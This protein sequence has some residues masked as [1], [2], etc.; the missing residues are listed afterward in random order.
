MCEFQHLGLIFR[1]K[2][3]EYLS[4]SIANVLLL[5]GGGTSYSGLAHSC[6]RSRGKN[7]LHGKAW[8]QG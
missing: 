4:S 3:G 1:I 7:R 2:V 5:G 8:V 6:F